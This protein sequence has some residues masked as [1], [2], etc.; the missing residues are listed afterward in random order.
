MSQKV[1]YDKFCQHYELDSSV[2]DSRSQ[3]NEYCK[4]LTV[5]NNVAADNITE[6]AIEK[7][8]NTK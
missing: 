2:I 6:K 5:F 3:Y 8:K 7:A 4:N 1:S